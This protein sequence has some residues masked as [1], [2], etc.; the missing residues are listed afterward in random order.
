MAK[1]DG[2]S[3]MSDKFVYTEE[4]QLEVDSSPEALAEAAAWRKAHPE[5]VANAK[6][7]EE[8]R[9]NAV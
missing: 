4:D 1:T 2:V 8:E 3:E 9:K 7:A 5:A 6:K